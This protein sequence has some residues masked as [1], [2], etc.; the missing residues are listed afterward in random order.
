MTDQK[1]GNIIIP[2]GSFILDVGR[3][4]KNF[5]ACILKEVQSIKSTELR[6]CID[7]LLIQYGYSTDT[8]C[9]QKHNKNKNKNKNK[10]EEK[11][12]KEN[13]KFIKP[14]IEEII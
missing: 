4:L 5:I 14:T 1:S 13:K 6:Y 8:V 7:S 12:I 3:R 11:D 9:I 2:A 10:E